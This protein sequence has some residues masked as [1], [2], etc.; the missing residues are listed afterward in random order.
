MAVGGL[1][2][3]AECE[4]W[5][6]LTRTCESQVV[7]IVVIDLY[8]DGERSFDRL[9]VLR[10]H[11]PRVALVAYVSLVPHR[12]R[13]LFD[14]GRFGV[15]ALVLADEDDDPQRL[16]EL[17]E[18]ASS[19]G[20]GAAVRLAL[21]PTRPT[22][23]DAVL[24][25]VTRAAD[26]LSPLALARILGISRRALALHLAADGFP[27]P[28]RIL[29]WGR[30]IVA[31]HILED[32]RRSADGV[33]LSL[34]FP[35]GSAFRNTCQRYIGATPGEI[36]DRGGAAYVLQSFLSRRRPT[37]IRPSTRSASRRT[38]VESVRLIAAD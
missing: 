15:D 17:V 29:T 22:V 35:S 4:D 21:P 8:A 2:T 11:F 6:T 14:A 1:Y 18:Q 24:L 9:R 5:Q 10:E 13:D 30:L 28:R 16:L 27:P 38:P 3:L 25:S 33:A 36:R 19:R 32:Q 26:A 20:V 31:A 34:D 23:R 37:R 12:A 7:Q